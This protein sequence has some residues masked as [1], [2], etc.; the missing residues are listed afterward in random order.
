[1]Q[2]KMV[3]Y[4]WLEF[5]SSHISKINVTSVL[6][7]SVLLSILNDVSHKI[8]SQKYAQKSIFGR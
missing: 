6:K 3:A 5:I 1:M 4:E 2:Y 7:R 8:N